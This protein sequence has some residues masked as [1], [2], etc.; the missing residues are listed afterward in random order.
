M[1]RT[2]IEIDDEL[3]VLVMRRYGYHSKEDAVHAALRE[4]A[5]RPVPPDELSS[6]RPP[7]D[8][9]VERRM[10]WNDDTLMHRP[11]S[12]PLEPISFSRR[13]GGLFLKMGAVAVL[14]FGVPMF[15]VLWTPLSV[16]AAL[17]LMIAG[18]TLSPSR[19]EQAS[20]E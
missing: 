6:T 16:V 7:I 15:H 4:V 5:G 20:T 8:P 3:L 11:R 10:S 1:P 9:E 17:G 14:V 13:M 2:N 19:R 18:S 12:G